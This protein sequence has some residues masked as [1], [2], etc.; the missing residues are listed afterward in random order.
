M[1]GDQCIFL[2]LGKTCVDRM[3]WI[4]SLEQWERTAQRSKWRVI[5][6]LE[7]DPSPGRYQFHCT[8]EVGSAVRQGESVSL[9]MTQVKLPSPLLPLFVLAPPSHRQLSYFHLR[10]VVPDWE[11]WSLQAP[12]REMFSFR[13]VN[14]WL[15]LSSVSHPPCDDSIWSL[16]ASLRGASTRGGG[17]YSVSPLAGTQPASSWQQAALSSS[18]PFSII[19][20]F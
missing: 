6:H 13:S 5:W 3:R 20:S 2:A 9:P 14:C 11:L 16:A 18:C 7:R 1:S 19:V 15:N 12:E 17:S 8:G 10:K 4:T